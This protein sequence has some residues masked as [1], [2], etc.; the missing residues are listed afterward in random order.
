MAVGVPG[1]RMT[2]LDSPSPVWRGVLV[3][4]GPETGPCP[5][6]LSW[7]PDPVGVKA[8][9]WREAGRGA[10]AVPGHPLSTSAGS[11]FMGY[12]IKG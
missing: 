8:L 11:L 2:C 6:L 7:R 1:A 4:A 5:W 3:L 10:G 12:L 9:G